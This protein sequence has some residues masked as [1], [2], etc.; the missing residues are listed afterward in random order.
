[1]VGAT[2]GLLAIE[3]AC[4]QAAATQFDYWQHI[5]QRLLIRPMPPSSPSVDGF[6]RKAKHFR[7]EMEALRRILLDSPLTEDV[8]WRTPCYTFNG[9]NVAFIGAQKDCCVLS[10]LKGVLMKDPQHLLEMPGENT[11]AARV[12][13]FSSLDE[14]TK[15]DDTLRAYVAE[16]IELE[17]AGKKFDFRNDA[18]LPLPEE[19]TQQMAEM[20]ELKDAFEKLT[21]GRRRAYVLHFSAPKQSKT[22]TARIE[23]CI[24]NIL[25]GV[26]LTDDYRAQIKRGPSKRQPKR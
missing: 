26:G 6:L 13:R 24:D 16:A 17:K 21:P 20:P 4:E 25:Q 15:H 5:D 14:I 9:A 8:K 22:R 3:P 11:R 18:E 2:A 7:T 1:V 10:F 19:L 12:I 23:K